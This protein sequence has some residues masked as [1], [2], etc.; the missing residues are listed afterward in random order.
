MIHRIICFVAL[1]TFG[2]TLTAQST[3]GEPSY[4]EWYVPFCMVASE[5][6]PR[7]QSVHSVNF[8]R[9]EWPCLFNV[10]SREGSALLTFYYEDGSTRS[11]EIT[12]LPQ[13]VTVLAFHNAENL[14]LLSEH[15]AFGVKIESDVEIFPQFSASEDGEKFGEGLFRSAGFARMAH[16]GPLSVRE[17]KWLLPDGHLSIHKGKGEDR[18]WFYFLNPGDKAADLTLKMIYKTKTLTKKLSVEP[19]SIRVYEPGSDPD[20]TG[21]FLN[22]TTY[23]VVVESSEPIVMEAIRRYW[24][25]SEETPINS[26]QI[27]P[28]AI[29]DLKISDSA[30]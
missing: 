24:N 16:P 6:L 7:G 11:K 12:L 29:G 25:S 27:I 28:F 9:N 5:R 13:A 3:A 20:I 18:D 22:T 2:T 17:T 19:H 8:K 10:T 1:A 21:A 23:G 4:K 14:E 26:W 30:F 15:A